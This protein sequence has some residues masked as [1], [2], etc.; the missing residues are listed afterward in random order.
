PARRLPQLCIPSASR[1][2]QYKPA[3]PLTVTTGRPVPPFQGIGA[4]V[5]RCTGSVHG[6]TGSGSWV[7]WFGVEGSSFTGS[8]SRPDVKPDRRPLEPE[9]LAQLVDEKSLVGE[10]EPGRDVRKEHKRRRRDAGLR[11]VQNPDV[12]ASGACWR[13]RSRNLRYELVQL[14]RLDAF[15]ARR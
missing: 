1:G 12:A 15:S 7:L 3:K 14:R 13:M 6:C 4:Q 11:S 2:T 8:T 5:H 9:P 10:V